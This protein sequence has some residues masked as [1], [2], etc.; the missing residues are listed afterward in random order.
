[1]VADVHY[2][3]DHIY[4]P[5]VDRIETRMVVNHNAENGWIIE[6]ALQYKNAFLHEDFKSGKPVYIRKTAREDGSYTQG[7]TRV[8]LRLKLYGNPSVTYYYVDGLLEFLQNLKAQMNEAEVC[9]KRIELETG[10]VI[11]AIKIDDF[12][13][14]S[15]TIETM[16]DFYEAMVT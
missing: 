1:M 14:T 15:S 16:N 11:E 12:L 9:L 3:P 6:R 7:K 2:T 5:M 13:E 4:A 10:S 8:V